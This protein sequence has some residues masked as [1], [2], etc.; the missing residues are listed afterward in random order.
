M[1]NIRKMTLMGALVSLL[2]V[3][4]Q[5]LT[6]LP[7]IQFSTLLIL[8]FVSH[9]TFKESLTM[10]LVYVV[11]DSLWM[12]AINPFYMV[13]MFLGWSVIP[14]AYHSFLRRTQ[15]PHLLAFF[16]VFMASLYGLA[17]MPFAVFQTG[18]SM[19]VYLVADIPFQILMALSNFLTILWLYEPLNRRFKS[20][21]QGYVSTLHLEALHE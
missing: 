14:V 11:L 8:I 7:N 18:V 5:I 13:P 12:G 21:L 9:F 16:G 10:L 4:E 3:Q 2:L 1:M 15:N 17:F 6:F 19:S 20:A